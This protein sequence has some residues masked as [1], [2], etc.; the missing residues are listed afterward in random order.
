MRIL[1]AN[2]S[3]E[4][5][6]GVESS[7]PPVVPELQARAHEIALLYANTAAERGPTTIETG[8]SWSVKDLGLAA[9]AAAARAWRPDVCFAHNMRYLDIEEAMVDTWP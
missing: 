6:R 3:R 9:A 7:W 8:A 2:E 5:A 1:L 4:G